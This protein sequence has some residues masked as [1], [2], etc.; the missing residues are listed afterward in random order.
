[1]DELSNNSNSNASE[2]E[3]RLLKKEEKQR[4]H[5]MLFLFSLTLIITG[6]FFWF[7]S[8]FMAEIFGFYKPSEHEGGFKLWGSFFILFSTVGFAYLY[9]SGFNPKIIKETTTASND[10]LNDQIELVTLLRS[11][12]KSIEKGKLEN[13]LTASER[14]EIIQNISE[15]IETQLNESL[16]TKIEETYGNTIYSD[17]LSIKANDLL[18]E[19]VTR[20]KSQ[21]DKLQ[22]KA[23]V[24]LIYGISATIIAIFIL[25]FM[26]INTT[27]PTEV[28]TIETIF[29]YISRFFLV[30]LVQ[31]IAIFFLRLYKATLN[32]VM[33]MNNE[34]TN[35]EAKRDSLILS[36]STNQTEVTTKILT[37]LSSTERNFTLKKG[38]SSIFN[39]SKSTDDE[40]INLEVLKELL[41]KVK[42]Q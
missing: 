17:K 4:S 1:M 37:K 18:S 42:N 32:D 35:F 30:L 12:D 22:E 3:K 29:H 33:Y 24:N 6:F 40:S 14:Q 20:L 15:T 36:L 5:K 19:T 38:E 8:N 9:M 39:Q 31:G 21:M 28:N 23:T 11:I 34:M 41:S 2:L 7:Q 16:L 26:L 10:T 13:V 25:I 27:P